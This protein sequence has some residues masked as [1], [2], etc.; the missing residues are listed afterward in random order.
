MRYL[1]S[2]DL[3]TPGKDYKPLWQALA[4]LGAVRVLESEWTVNH[5]NSTPL[6][7][8]NYCIKH[9]DANDR[10]LVTE[11]PDN[12]AYRNLIAQPKAA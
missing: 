11:M 8:A 7:I 4:D 10:I 9:M 3:I 1:I 12:Y 2:Y 5:S 6:A